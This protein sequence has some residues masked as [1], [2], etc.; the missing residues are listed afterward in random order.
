MKFLRTILVFSGVFGAG[1]LATWAVAGAEIALSLTK[2]IGF[3]VCF[4]LAM[5]PVA[6]ALSVTDGETR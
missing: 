6:M 2:C 5:W 4:M 1:I 3:M